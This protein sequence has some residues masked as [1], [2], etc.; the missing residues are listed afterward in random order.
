M[1]TPDGGGPDEA[2]TLGYGDTN[3]YPDRVA[4]GSI[5]LTESRSGGVKLLTVHGEHDLYTAPRLRQ[6][7]DALL[8][9]RTSVVV[10][11]TG[12]T[13]V[14]SSILGALLNARQRA[15][16]GRCGFA[17]CLQSGTEPSVRRI[18]EM[19]G[20]VETLPVLD[21]VEEAERAAVAGPPEEHD[22]GNG[23]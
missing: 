1:P 20:L 2:A 9:S 12:A 6:Q 18:F 23:Q 14:D 16:E 22:G 21:T 13:F 10:D 7:L 8:D 17:V 3:G 5:A 11:L 4:T 15:I 19:T